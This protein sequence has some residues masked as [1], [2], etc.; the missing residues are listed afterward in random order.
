M[1]SFRA[2]FETA[3]DSLRI[4]VPVSLKQELQKLAKESGRPLS[5]YVYRILDD[6]VKGKNIFS[7]NSPTIDLS[8]LTSGSYNI[9]AKIDSENSAKIIGIQLV[10]DD[11]E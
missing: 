1:E 2:K 9:V 8:S 6:Y 4:T 7:T 10:K 3:T 11:A 5:N